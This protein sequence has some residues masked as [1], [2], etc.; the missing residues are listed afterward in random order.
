[1]HDFQRCR[2]HV[3]QNIISCTIKECD[4]FI[5][6]IECLKTGLEE[7]R[8]IEIQTL[9]TQFHIHNSHLKGQL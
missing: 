7:L 8:V 5:P 2:G 6:L 4:V 3:S 9:Y 1:M